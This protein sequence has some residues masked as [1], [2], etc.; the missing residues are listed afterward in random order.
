MVVNCSAPTPQK[1]S[2]NGVDDDCDG[3]TD[4]GFEDLDKDGLADCVDDDID[5]D[6]VANDQDN[7]PRTAN[8]DQTNTDNDDGGDACDDDD[9][10][11][12]IPL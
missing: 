5:G 12:K 10:G 2:C 9:D 7:C 6:G 1:E 8:P 4:E 11:E 3:Q